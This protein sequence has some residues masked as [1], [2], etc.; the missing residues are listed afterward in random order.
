MFLLIASA[1]NCQPVA[2]NPPATN[3]ASH[4]DVIDSL[5][6]EDA[7]HETVVCNGNIRIDPVEYSAED[8]EPPGQL[9]Q[10]RWGCASLSEDGRLRCVIYAT[11]GQLRHGFF[12][13]PRKWGEW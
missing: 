8:K 1:F 2:M 5:L 3:S 4:R 12:Q 9:Y 11:R 13:I 7:S 10:L 6:V